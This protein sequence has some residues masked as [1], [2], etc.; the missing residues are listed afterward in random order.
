MVSEC[1]VSFWESNAEAVL[2]GASFSLCERYVERPGGE[3]SLSQSVVATTKI[4]QVKESLA[5]ETLK[6]AEVKLLKRIG[7]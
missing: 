1:K 3:R 5:T 6:G 2:R 4:N 7:Q